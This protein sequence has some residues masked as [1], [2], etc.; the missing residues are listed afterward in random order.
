MADYYPLLAKAVAGL[1]NSTPETRRAIY[2]RARTALIGQ[3]R[4]MDPPVPEA[5][6]DRE[7]EALEAAVTRLEAEFAPE[8]A[9]EAIPRDPMAMAG[10][11]GRTSPTQTPDAEAVREPPGSDSGAAAPAASEDEKTSRPPPPF[12]VRREPRRLPESGANGGAQSN[13]GARGSRP[14][15]APVPPRS[16][17][18]RNG[19]PAL[20]AAPEPPAAAGPSGTLG[21]QGAVIPGAVLG[22]PV[23]QKLA[24]QESPAEGRAAQERAAQE[25][26]A[27]EPVVQEAISRDTGLEARRALD[28]KSPQPAA[29]IRS[30]AQRPFAPQPAREAAAPKR[31]W[32]VGAIVGLVVFLVAI[33]AFELRDRPEDL[34]GLKPAQPSTPVESG[35]T[36]KIVDRIGVGGA[37]SEAS[38]SSGA[39]AN[40]V[41]NRKDVAKAAT[42]PAEPAVAV[43]RRAALLVEAPDEQTKVRTFL[44]SVVWRV[45]NVSNGPGEPLTTAVRADIE[46]PEEK[47]QAA[48]TFQK[49]FDATLPASH[50][51]KLNFILAPGGP[52]ADIQQISVPQMRREDT[53]TG[54]ALSGVPVPVMKNAFLVGLSRGAAEPTNL[55]LL[56]SREWVDVPMLLSNGRIAKLTFEKGPSGQ[57]ALDDALASWQAQQ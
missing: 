1:S 57:R 30:D 2:E 53:A 28:A 46:I 43:A 48:M 55:D 10:L 56:R 5:D 40:I 49:N 52:L 24:A 41:A 42:E 9:A 44:G 36:G 17:S 47:L 27:Q 32:I 37:N 20:E 23:A 6:L 45:D 16:T 33:A 50:T 3:L 11:F 14:P 31:L 8:L 4:R 7:A 18:I 26:A 39:G 25:P 22:E 35:A 38:A 51:M 21:S 13:L 19:A 34:A 15:A 12:K 29:K 54:D